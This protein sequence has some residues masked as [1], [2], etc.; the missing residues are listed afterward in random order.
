M[1]R[2]CTFEA[3]GRRRVGVAVEGGVADL[4]AARTLLAGG[5][6]GRKWET[7][8]DLLAAG[9]KGREAV[10]QAEAWLQGRGVE[11]ADRA[12]EQVVF[13][14]EQVLFLAPVPNPPKILCIAGNYM[15][16]LQEG[17]TDVER[18]Q[19]IHVFTKVG[20]NVAIGHRAAIVI[21]NTVD[22]LDYEMEIGVVIG[23]TGRYIPPEKAARHIGG[24]TCFNDV[25]DRAFMPEA[26]RTIHWFPMKSQDHSAPMGPY[27]L[28]APEE[29]GPVDLEMRL[30]VN[31][32]LRQNARTTRMIFPPAWIVS[33]LSQW[34]TLEVGDVIATGT[35]A[36]N[37]WSRQ[38]FL[39]DGDVIELEIERI[40]RLRNR[41]AFEEP[42]YR[43][44][45][46]E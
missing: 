31:G 33:R 45:E 4:N 40:G 21:A 5:A 11:L 10:R 28:L 35:P 12:G 39:K 41:I 29:D 7:V 42:V 23:K 14:E 13:P 1:S 25:S 30:W 26:G 9:A 36:G 43:N 17:R 37:A 18:P 15:E 20:S 34:I 6:A 32:D 44:G 3:A 22:K 2:V 27:L 16:H 19:D 46:R 24:Y 8:I 38:D